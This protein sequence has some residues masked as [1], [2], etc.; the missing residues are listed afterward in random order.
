MS[1]RAFDI[2]TGLR[3]ALAPVE[4]PEEL[5]L[6]LES[7]AR[8]AGRA[9]RGRARGV[10]AVGDARP[11]QL[12]AAGS[13]AAAVVVG[14]GAAVGLVVL[15]TRRRRHRR[16]AQS[17]SV[18]ATSPSARCATAAA[19]RCACST[20]GADRDRTDPAGAREPERMPGPIRPARARRRG[21]DAADARGDAR[22]FE[23][24]LR[25][26]LR[27]PPSRSPTGWSARGNVAEDVAQE[28]FL[29]IWR[30]GARYDRARGSVR[31]WVLGIVH[32]RAIDEL[33]RVVVHDKRRAQRRG[34]RGALR[35]ARA[36]RRRGR[37]PRGGAR[38][39]A[40][41]WTRCP[42]SSGR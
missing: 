11:A 22:A 2:E 4:P 40:P 9:G 18:A 3:A 20:S 21:P 26:P 27:A 23:V 7:D 6:R 31:T 10:G 42:P 33:R 36:H 25:A 32:H 35:G 37:P 29:S 14:A 19:R 28:A 41:P 39:C 24:D 8:L 38:P 5:T 16:R 34:D 1:E 12:A 13:A 15:R 30:S 17:H